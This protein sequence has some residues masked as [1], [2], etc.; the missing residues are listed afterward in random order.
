[1]LGNPEYI[2]IDIGQYAIKIARVKKAGKSFV[3]NYLVYEILPEELRGG[4]DK[5]GLKDLVT[6]IL[7][8]HKIIKGQPVVHV[9]SGDTIMRNIVLPENTTRDA[10][11]GAI[12]LDLGQSL[13]FSLEQVYFDFDENMDA[14]GG[15]LAIAARR[16]VVDGKTSLFANRAKTLNKPQV[17]VDVFAYERLVEN[18][19]QAGRIHNTTVA[20]MDIGY[21]HSR[22]SIYQDGKYVFVREPQIGGN[23]VSE[24][25]RDVYDLDLDSAE[26]RKLNQN[27]GEEYEELVLMPYVSTLSEQMNLALDFYEASSPDAK[28][29][30]RIYVTGGGA[31]LRGLVSA[32]ST[33][34]DTPIELLDLSQFIK[35]QSK[36]TDLLQDGMNHGLAIALALEGK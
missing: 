14:N 4:K 16:D 33:K 28:P 30:E 3:S 5:E 24:I 12:E 26:S 10:V 2:G 18:L 1:M 8:T 22:I 19:V 21:T 23:Q 17:D 35:L 27:L 20:V 15:Y 34:I 32:L 36:Q 9:N 6:K 31:Q 29:I 13:P 25:I 7:K 11:E